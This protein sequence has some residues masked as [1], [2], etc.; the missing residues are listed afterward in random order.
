M[1]SGGF[2]LLTLLLEIYLELTDKIVR[3]LKLN[4]ISV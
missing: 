4:V 2:F 3:L 1:N